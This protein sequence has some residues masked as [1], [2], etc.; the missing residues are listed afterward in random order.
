MT[1][2]QTER[3]SSISID[4]DRRIIVSSSNGKHIFGCSFDGRSIV[5]PA[6]G[7]IVTLSAEKTA[8][9]V[10]ALA[11]VRPSVEDR[12]IGAPTDMTGW[13]YVDLT[14]ESGDYMPIYRRVVD[15]GQTATVAFGPQDVVA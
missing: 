4:G 1:T 14:D 7:T 12:R 8:E 6:Y 13:E 9:L 11:A 15:E 5:H 10:E 3:K 2:T